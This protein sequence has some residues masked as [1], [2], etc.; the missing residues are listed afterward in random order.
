MSV[1]T[2][3][4]DDAPKPLAPPADDGMPLDRKLLTGFFAMVF[5]MFMSILDIQIVSASMAEIQAGLSASASEVSWVQTSYLIA[6]VV[7]IPLSGTLSRIFSTRVVFCV[8]C[9]TFTFFSFLCGTATSIEEMIIWRAAQGFCG[10]AM[11]PT[12]FATIYL[13]FGRQRQIGF[14]ALIALTATL[15]PTIGP[16]LGGYITEAMSWH[17]L[18]FVNIIPGVIITFLVWTLMDIDAPQHGLWKHF[19]FGGLVLMAVF[20]GS[21]E[22]VLEE[23][24]R[25]DWFDSRRIV[26]FSIAAA[27]AAIFFFRRVLTRPHPVVDLS[28]FRDRNFAVGSI[29]GF[30][31]GVGL[32]GIT[33]I[34][35]LF[36]AR[37]RGMNAMEI[38]EM[39]WVTGLAMMITAPASMM[40]VRRFELD[41]RI[42]LAFGFSLMLA[43]SWSFSPMTADWGYDEMFLPQIMRGC[44]LMSCMMSIN[45]ISMGTLPMEQVK[46]A[47]GLYTLMR[48]IGGAF[49]LAI[50]T[51]LL[52]ERTAHHW[53]RIG[54]TLQA[55]D[56]RLENWLAGL[57][58][59]YEA[60][61][62]MLNGTDEMAMRL[63]SHLVQREAWVLAFSD[64]FTALA[65]IFALALALV[66]V[67]SRPSHPV[68]VSE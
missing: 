20:L 53:Q 45:M 32:Y 23:G 16:T 59:H 40:I 67:A 46:H 24:A 33:F 25:A 55:G 61:G 39:L 27:I 49:G 8:S 38:G 9:A 66:P 7:M 1:T 2:F 22:Y 26:W 12:V 19:D 21:M 57:S 44:G 52:N 43:A 47:S 41:P 15:A 30:A 29:F 54:E 11:I 5:G 35:P 28:A 14:G 17:W 62:T 6:E 58:A 51:T 65:G 68:E 36:L 31:L 48:N 4:G 34:L 18:F 50:L 3:D 60:S 63:L 64:I 37:V 56:P 42:L 10:G 13:I